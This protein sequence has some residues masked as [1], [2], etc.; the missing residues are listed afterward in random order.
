LEVGCTVIASPDAVA[1]SVSLDPDQLSSR[2]AAAL[3]QGGT[4]GAMQD[5]TQSERDALYAV[6]YGMYG[7]ARY[8]QALPLFAHL[9]IL[10]HMERRYL[11]ALA[12]TLQV[13]GRHDEALPHY[14]A[15]M[16]LGFDD[17]EPAMRTG[18]CLSAL[19]KFAEAQES[20]ELALSLC[21]TPSHA[22]VRSRCSA[23]LLSLREKHASH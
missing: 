6:A 18:E 21:K 23:S 8:E 13:L 11:F 7:Q 2:F 9:V 19:E 10:D 4:L 1:S 15:A 17:P 12:A 5:I 20:F 3:A 14:I 16:V 22:R